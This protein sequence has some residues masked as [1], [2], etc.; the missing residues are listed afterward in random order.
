M[1]IAT[2]TLKNG[3]LFNN[4][5]WS[6]KEQI[7]Q[8]A[9][10]TSKLPSTLLVE[11]LGIATDR[12]ITRPFLRKILTSMLRIKTQFATKE[13]EILWTFSLFTIKVFKTDSILYVRR[14]NN[15]R[16]LRGN[17]K[18]WTL[19]R[20]ERSFRPKWSNFTTKDLRIGKKTKKIEGQ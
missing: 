12:L 16:E 20:R 4:N 19:F 8:S 3:K 7:V 10:V 15:L 1:K 14:W 6:T 11:M 5:S 18:R 2:L 13:R 9:R 17:P